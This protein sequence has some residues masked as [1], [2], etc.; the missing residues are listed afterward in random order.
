MVQLRGHHTYDAHTM[1]HDAVRCCKAGKKPNFT[2]ALIGPFSSL[3]GLKKSTSLKK[4]N[5]LNFI[6]QL[7]YSN[8]FWLMLTGG[9]AALK[10]NYKIEA[11]NLC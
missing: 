7:T 4:L 10:L 8:L 1:L 2:Q 6:N 9:R 5:F 11:T 3:A